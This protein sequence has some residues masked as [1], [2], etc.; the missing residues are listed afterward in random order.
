MKELAL[1]RWVF[2]LAGLLFA[3][4]GG[5]PMPDETSVIGL[6]F[7]TSSEFADNPPPTNVDVTLT[8]PGPSRVIYRATLALPDF[9]SGVYNCPAD[10]GYT[11]TIVFTREPHAA[12][13]A[14]LNTGGCRDATISGAPPVRQTNDPYWSLLAQNLGVDVATLF[15]TAAQ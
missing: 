3:G 2:L 9:P 1:G 15:E 5:G 10:L 13:T 6:H 7:S 8:D 11:H 12:I 4:C 14:T